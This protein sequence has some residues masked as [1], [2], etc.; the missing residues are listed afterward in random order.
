MQART[1]L[2]IT[3]VIILLSTHAAHAQIKRT[4]DGKPDLSGIWSPE[5]MS[6]IKSQA[7]G[8]LLK[9]ISANLKRD[10]DLNCTYP[11][12]PRIDFEKPFK[13]LQS[14][15]EVV[16][17][18]QDYTTY[19]QI[20]TDGRPLPQDPQPTWLGYSVGKWDGDTL[21][22]DSTGFNDES[23]LDSLGTPHSDALRVTERFH[24]RD[25]DHLDIQVTVNDPKTFSRPFTVTGHAR[26]EPKAELTESICLEERGIVN[27]RTNASYEGQQ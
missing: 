5:P 22:V 6:A 17:L 3:A 21:V 24:R 14:A 12:V 8:L 20:F 15:D 23:W 9:P 18:Y 10:P 16:V 19:R 4:S 25:A 13:I 7:K 11:G 1:K 26:L 27:A 2:G